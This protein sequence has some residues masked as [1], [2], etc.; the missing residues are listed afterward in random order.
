MSHRVSRRQFLGT[1][2]IAAGG[3]M[4]LSRSKVLGNVLGANQKV[5]MAVAG[6][7]GR[8]VAHIDE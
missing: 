3:T 6:I 4:A 8:G 1:S 2:L 7:N 5:R